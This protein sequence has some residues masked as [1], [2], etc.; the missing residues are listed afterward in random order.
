VIQQNSHL[1][2]TLLNPGEISGL[3]SFLISAGAQVEEVHKNK[4]SLEDV[5]LKMMEEESNDA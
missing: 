3:L 1:E 2:I 4:A 5:F